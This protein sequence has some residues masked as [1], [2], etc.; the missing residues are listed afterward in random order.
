M[1]AIA[2]TLAVPVLVVLLLLGIAA[3][4]ALAW[5]LLPELRKSIRIETRRALGMLRRRRA[6]RA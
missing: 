6:A 3:I 5:I 2:K 1:I 4:A